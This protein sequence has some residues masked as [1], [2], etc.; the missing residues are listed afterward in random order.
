MIG[1]LVSTNVDGLLLR[2]CATQQGSPS[3]GRL[4]M[5]G[6]PSN[7]KP[8]EFDWE[9]MKAALESP[10][11]AVPHGITREEFRK[12][13]QKVADEAKSQTQSK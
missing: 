11:H 12:F 13:L 8:G 5:S 6:N 9:R 10:S 1:K 3:E 7:L 2:D 4:F